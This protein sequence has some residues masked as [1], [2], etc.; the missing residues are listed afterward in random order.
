MRR[1]RIL[2]V[3]PGRRATGCPAASHPTRR[4]TH[5]RMGDYASRGLDAS[6][7]RVS[8]FGLRSAPETHD[9]LAFKDQGAERSI[10]RRRLRSCLPRFHSSMAH[11]D[12][13][14]PQ[15][16]HRR[17]RDFATVRLH[18]RCHAFALVN[19]PCRATHA[20]NS[21]RVATWPRQPSTPGEVRNLRVNILRRCAYRPV[22]NPL[23]AL[24]LPS[25]PNPRAGSCPPSA[26]R[27][28]G[29]PSNTGLSEP[30]AHYA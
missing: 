28:L 9:Y 13:R 27:G 24:L 1:T 15:Q 10:D 3:Y 12:S 5:Q 29:V 7:E 26:Q 11:C 30:K 2:A 17:F 21:R 20:G 22:A 14:E 23:Q 4:R 19:T 18:T 16:H 6:V 25:M 8:R